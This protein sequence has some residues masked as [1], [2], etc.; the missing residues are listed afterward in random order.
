[1]TPMRRRAG[2][3]LMDWSKLAPASRPLAAVADKTR[4]EV[5]LGF[6]LSSPERYLG[7]RLLANRLRELLHLLEDV[8]D[9]YEAALASK[10]LHGLEEPGAHCAPGRGEAQRVDEVPRPLLLLGS[11]PSHALLDRLLRPLR[12]GFEPLFEFREVLPDELLAELS[13]ELFRVVVELA[14]VEVADG[15]GDLGRAGDALLQQVH[16]PGEARHVVLEL[17]FRRRAGGGEHG[18]GE[19]R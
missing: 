9:P 2:N 5:R 11:Q 15:V 10:K 18:G 14:A 7:V 6:I 16:D 13:S 19:H 17:L 3:C 12:Q 4:A 8:L 1:M